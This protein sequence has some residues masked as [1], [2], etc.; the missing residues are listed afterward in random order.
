MSANREAPIVVETDSGYIIRTNH[1]NWIDKQ[2]E[3]HTSDP[4]TINGHGLQVTGRGLLG[5][6]YRN[7]SGA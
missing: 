6:L 3:I 2:R 4:V 5:T 7:F 1:L